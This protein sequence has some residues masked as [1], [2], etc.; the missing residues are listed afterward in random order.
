MKNMPEKNNAKKRKIPY[1]ST[2]KEQKSVI[3][4]LVLSDPYLQLYLNGFIEVYIALLVLAC[5]TGCVLTSMQ[6]T[7]KQRARERRVKRAEIPPTS[8]LA[9]M[10]WYIF[11]YNYQYLSITQLNSTSLLPENRKGY[12]DRYVEHRPDL[13]NSCH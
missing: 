2:I 11:I 9:H 13:Q 12:S 6:I 1:C 10:H 7:E 8:E 5:P 3:S 4:S